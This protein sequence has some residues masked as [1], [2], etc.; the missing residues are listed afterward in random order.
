MKHRFLTTATLCL[1]AGACASCTRLNLVEQLEPAD[2]RV[3]IINRQEPL[4]RQG[5][6]PQRVTLYEL[7]GCYYVPITVY[8]GKEDVPLFGLRFADTETPIAKY[9]R[10]TPDPATAQMWLF[11]LSDE[12]ATHCLKEL[13]PHK[14][15]IEVKQPHDINTAP[16]IAT[17]TFDYKQARACG[18]VQSFC[19]QSVQANQSAAYC[20]TP[21]LPVEKGT[22]SLG[23][24]LAWGPVWCADAAGNVALFAAESALAIPCG[25]IFCGLL[26][27]SSET[28]PHI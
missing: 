22:R 21:R 12:E 17:S 16:V 19:P 23:Y 14:G 6:V 26:L 24:Y 5:K 4:P 25:L 28:L 15:D 20:T 9:V 10:Y 27:I 13:H 3:P 2:K 11:P 7:N 18:K 1:A 8:M